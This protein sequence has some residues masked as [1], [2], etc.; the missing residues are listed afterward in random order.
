VLGGEQGRVGAGDGLRAAGAPDEHADD[1]AEHE[2]DG[3]SEDQGERRI[4]I[5]ECRKP[6][7]HRPVPTRSAAHRKTKM[8]GKCLAI[9]LSA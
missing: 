8:F 5:K 4:H 1:R 3:E 2:P 6:H 7:R 9:S